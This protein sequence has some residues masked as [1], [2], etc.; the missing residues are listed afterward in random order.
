MFF[1]G[2]MVSGKSQRALKIRTELP[3]DLYVLDLRNAKKS[4]AIG[5]L[6]VEEFQSAALTALWGGLSHPDIDWDSHQHF[7]WKSFDDVVLAGGMASTQSGDLASYAIVGQGYLN[8]N[9]RFG[10]HFTLIDAVCGADPR[11]NY[12]QI[13]FAGGG[14]EYAGRHLRVQFLEAVLQH[15][16]F[17][18]TTK[19]DLIDGRLVERSQEEIYELLDNLGKLLGATKLMDLVLREGGQVPELVSQYL[20]GV[21]TFTQ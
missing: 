1:L 12:A 17:T 13:R 20:N 16:G 5:S 6:P 2:D 11:L 3:I 19:G 15:Y 4:T 9:M 21:Y 10:Y 14:G 18:T 7:D 8:V